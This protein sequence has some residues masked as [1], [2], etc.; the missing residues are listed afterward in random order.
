[1]LS[2]V[3]IDPLANTARN[4]HA[5]SIVTGSTLPVSTCL[6]SLTNVSVAATTRWIG[7]LSHSAVSIECAS[8]SPVTPDPA[9]FASSRHRALPPWGTAA[10]IV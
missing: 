10:E 9:T 2:N 5:S 8:R 6:R 3:P 1:M 4:M 7:P